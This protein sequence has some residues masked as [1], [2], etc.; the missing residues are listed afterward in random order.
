MFLP[1]CRP[2][3]GLRELSEGGSVCIPN[4]LH[5]LFPSTTDLSH[6]FFLFNPSCFS[7]DEL[8][9]LVFLTVSLFFFEYR[10]L[11]QGQEHV[12]GFARAS[13]CEASSG[14]QYWPLSAGQ[15]VTC[16]VPGKDGGNTSN[17]NSFNIFRLGLSLTALRQSWHWLFKNNNYDDFCLSKSR[18]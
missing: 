13:L 18:V 6:C 10:L 9:C 17:G 15:D 8:S 1:G 2:C 16:V 12:P 14:M 4:S 11:C 5:L 3:S 7:K